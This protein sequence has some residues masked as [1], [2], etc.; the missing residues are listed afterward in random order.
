M[1]RL[2]SLTYR[3]LSKNDILNICK[4]KNQYWQYGLSENI[5][6]FERNINKKDIHNLFFIKKELVGYTLLRKRVAFIKNKKLKSKINYL[7][8]DTLIIKKKFRKRNYSKILMDFNSNIIIRK[9]L[10]SFLIC[11]NR[12]INYYK[13]FNWTKLGKKEFQLMDHKSSKNGMTFNKKFELKKN[14]VLYY[15]N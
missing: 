5:N 6:W 10:H 7:Y 11:L 15:I 14:K 3:Q 1:I 4:L 8:F 13:K 9:R 2:R 12:S